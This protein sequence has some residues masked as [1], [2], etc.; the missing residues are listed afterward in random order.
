[1]VAEKPKTPH[2]LCPECRKPFSVISRNGGSPQRYCSPQHKRAWEN[3]QIA[4]GMKVVL[5]AQAWQEM[6]H[7]KSPPGFRGWALSELC[8]IVNG[9]TAEDKAAGRMSPLD[10]LRDRH[11]ADGTLEAKR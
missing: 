5:L 8:G 7:R 4:R 2:R 11:R 3:R 9:Y 1:M 10:I 6:R